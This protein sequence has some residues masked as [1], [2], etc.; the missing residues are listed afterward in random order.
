MKYKIHLKGEGHSVV[1]LKLPSHI[2]EKL[3]EF[4]ETES[5]TE[6]L[7][8][9]ELSIENIFDLFGESSENRCFNNQYYAIHPEKSYLTITDQNGKIILDEHYLS[10]HNV[11]KSGNC[12]V[13]DESPNLFFVCESVKGSF[14]QFEENIEKGFDL[15]KIKPVLQEY[16]ENIFSIIGLEY[17][18]K[19]LRNLG[20]ESP[21]D[22]SGYLSFYF[23]Y[24]D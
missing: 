22:G 16:P 14:F 10:G 15:D 6:D 8:K 7:I 2:F 12:R 20:T 13:K 19:E 23:T 9:K 18:G 1:E 17:D 11:F 3:I 21:G 5:L 24:S 4:Y